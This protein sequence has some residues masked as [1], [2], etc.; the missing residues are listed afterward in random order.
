MRSR[1]NAVSVYVHQLRRKLAATS[2]AT[3]RG[4]GYYV[5]RPEVSRWKSIRTRLLVSLLS[6]VLLSAAASAALTYTN[7]LSEAEALFDYQLRQMALSLRDQGFIA[8]DQAAALANDDFDFVVQI[9]SVDGTR[10]LRVASGACTAARAV[11]GFAEIP[12]GQR[13][14]A[15]LQ[16][17][18]RTTG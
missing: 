15:H 8:P 10:I 2:F 1:A 11:L 7:V 13:N 6:V 12:T 14:L 5:G 4:V 16:H 18:N 9:W 3:V 17:H